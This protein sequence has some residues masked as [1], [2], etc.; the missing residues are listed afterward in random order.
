MT[1]GHDTTR[2]LTRR[3]VLGASAALGMVVGGGGAA[4][5]STADDRRPSADPKSHAGAARADPGAARADRPA[6]ADAGEVWGASPTGLGT[7]V[8]GHGH[9]GVV[10]EGTHTGVAGD[11]VIGV[12]GTTSSRQ[13]DEAGV[14]VWAEAETPGGL[15]L[16]ADGPARF[17][18]RADFTGVTAFSRSGVVTVPPG[19]T[20]VTTTGVA[21]EESTVILA[22]VQRRVPG[23]RLHA[24]ETDPAAGSFTTFLTAAP[25]VEV[26]VAWFAVG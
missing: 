1:D 3:G 23:V 8:R 2:R 22:T 5:A 21:L 11:G 10:G 14:G 20:S 24:V 16:R 26:P 18:G 25:A 15:A 19:A 17:N 4:L 12:H 9:H 6:G 7:G 13:D